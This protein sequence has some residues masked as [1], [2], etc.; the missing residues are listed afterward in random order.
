M[1]D[2]E[3]SVSESAAPVTVQLAI[4]YSKVH[5][6]SVSTSLPEADRDTRV[7]LATDARAYGFQPPC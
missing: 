7:A 1:V 5:L 2:G 6:R 3:R 4:G